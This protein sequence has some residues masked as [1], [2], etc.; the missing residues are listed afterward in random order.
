MPR[1]LA[2]ALTS[3]VTPKE[4]T[5]LDVY[6]DPSVPPRRGHYP[7]REAEAAPSGPTKSMLML[8]AVLDAHDLALT[9]DKGVFLL[10]EDIGDPPGGPREHVEIAGR[11]AP[12]SR[13]VR[14]QAQGAQRL[15]EFPVIERDRQM[16]DV[17][18]DLGVDAA[19]P[20]G[21]HGAEYLIPVGAHQQ[22][23]ALE[24][25]LQGFEAAHVVLDALPASAG[26]RA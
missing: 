1:P 3:K 25:E 20:D 7:R 4:E 5:L 13:Q 9:Q 24:S 18:V 6:A 14:P 16:R 8:D 12:E 10:G 23:K 26:P 2:K 11:P 15:P 22:V 17:A 21:Q 19:R